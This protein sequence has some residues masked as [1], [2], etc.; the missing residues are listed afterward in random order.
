MLRAAVLRAAVLRAAV[1]RAA[2]LLMIP[3]PAARSL[4]G[5]LS[6]QHPRSRLTPVLSRG[7]C[8]SI[9]I[10]WSGPSSKSI[11]FSLKT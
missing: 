9:G 2:V 8:L 7:Q 3:G 5:L 11:I 1:L 10:L 4:Q 6:V